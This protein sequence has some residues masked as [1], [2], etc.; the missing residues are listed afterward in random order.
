MC[1]ILFLVH[2]L[3][4]D[5]TDFGNLKLDLVSNPKPP[6]K[7]SGNS[8]FIVG[9]S[10]SF[11]KWPNT[12]SLIFEFPAD[13]VISHFLERFVTIVLTNGCFNT[14]AHGIHLHISHWSSSLTILSTISSMLEFFILKCSCCTWSI[15]AFSSSPHQLLRKC[16][17]ISTTRFNYII[18]TNEWP[19]G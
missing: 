6:S 7:Q 3:S 17:D 12:Y 14:M 13:L 10:M 19:N 16:S 5:C 11:C 1:H 18:V 4:S 8:L 9:T 2:M 15:S